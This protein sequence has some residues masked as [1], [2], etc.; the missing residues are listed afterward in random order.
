MEK[1]TTPLATVSSTGSVTDTDLKNAYDT[2]NSTSKLLAVSL[3]QQVPTTLGETRVVYN[4]VQALLN[5]LRKISLYIGSQVPNQDKIR[6]FEDTA[7]QPYWMLDEIV[8]GLDYLFGTVE[9]LEPGFDYP[10]YSNYRNKTT[11]M[12]AIIN[13]QDTFQLYLADA[14]SPLKK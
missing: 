7:A 5:D 13:D 14:D 6:G 12:S 1:E 11:L 8:I 4:T 3:P 2:I 9:G 10:V